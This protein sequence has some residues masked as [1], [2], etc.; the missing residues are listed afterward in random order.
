MPDNNHTQDL[1]NPP[2]TNAN[3]WDST[4]FSDIDNDGDSDLLL[5]LEWGPITILENNNG[6]FKNVYCI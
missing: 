1:Y 4:V 5:A 3:D 6:K 2:G